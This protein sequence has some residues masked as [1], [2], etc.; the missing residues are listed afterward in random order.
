LPQLLLINK[1][2]TRVFITLNFAGQRAGRDA[3]ITDPNI[4]R[5]RVRNGGECRRLG[6]NSG[7]HYLRLT[8]DEKR[9]VVS[10]YFLVEDLYQAV[11]SMQKAT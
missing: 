1:A 9:L 2:G 5:Q 8:S 10:D 3:H 11:C 7:P 6:L 4:L